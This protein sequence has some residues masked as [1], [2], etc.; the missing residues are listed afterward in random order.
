MMYKHIHKKHHEWNAPISIIA[1]YCHPLEHLLSNALPIYLGPVVSGAH[2]V[3]AI[4]W[5]T[6]SSEKIR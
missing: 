5:Y 1:Q 6:T 4:A 3:T 2:P